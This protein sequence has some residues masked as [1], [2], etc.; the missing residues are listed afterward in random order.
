MKGASLNDLEAFVFGS[1]DADEGIFALELEGAT[2]TG[3]A[4]SASLDNAKFVNDR[5]GDGA[6][7]LAATKNKGGSVAM[8]S[9]PGSRSFDGI[10]YGEI[11]TAYYANNWTGNGATGKTYNVAKVIKNGTIV[12]TVVLGGTIE[13]SQGVAQDYENYQN[14]GSTDGKNTAVASGKVAGGVAGAWA[15]AKA[16]AAIGGIIGGAVGGWVGSEVG[17]AAVEEVYK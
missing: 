12:T 15:G 4:S 13:V 17:G 5:L 1:M 10:R 2:I 6:D 9:K 8:W 14:T 7:I 3:K 16:G 11:K